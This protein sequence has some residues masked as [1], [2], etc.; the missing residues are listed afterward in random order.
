MLRLAEDKVKCVTS[1]ATFFQGEAPRAGYLQRRVVRIL[2]FVSG[3]NPA[4]H[5]VFILPWDGFT[6]NLTRLTNASDGL[7]HQVPELQTSH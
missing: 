2:L 4:F 3:E 1:A 6:K 5:R 7:D